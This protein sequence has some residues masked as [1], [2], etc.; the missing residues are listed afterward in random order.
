MKALPVK[1][2]VATR[3]P[4]VSSLFTGRAS[5]LSQLDDFFMQR[6]PGNHP[7]R[8]FLLYGM[9]GAGKT[10]VGLKFVQEHAR[11]YLL[12]ISMFSLVFHYL[13]CLR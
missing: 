10:Q 8:E 9:G 7:R 1:A 4:V 12:Q 5:V 3:R 13:I 2:E 6:E 11:R